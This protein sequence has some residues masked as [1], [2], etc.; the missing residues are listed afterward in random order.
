[1]KLKMGNK[2][3]STPNLPKK[4][5]LLTP[6]YAHEYEIFVFSEY[7]ACVFLLPPFLRFAFLPYWRRLVHWAWWTLE[8]AEHISCNFTC[9]YWNTGN[10]EKKGNIATK[11]NKILNLPFSWLGFLMINGEIEVKGTTKLY[12]MHYHVWSLFC[13][14][15]TK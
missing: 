7:L 15:G 11:R 10:I 2:K 13:S 1:M 3:K 4:R 14:N 9:I 5:T 6:W 12:F 8:S